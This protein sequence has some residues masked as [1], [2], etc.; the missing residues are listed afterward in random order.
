M[1]IESQF[2]P[3]VIRSVEAEPRPGKAIP[4]KSGFEHPVVAVGVDEKRRRLIMIS[5]DPDA[6]SAA[7][8][9]TD[10]QA[11]FP[12]YSVIL[13]RPIAVNLGR[14]ADAVAKALGTPTLSLA[15]LP[16]WTPPPAMSKKV[17]EKLEKKFQEKWTAILEDGFGGTFHVLEYASVNPIAAWQEVIS[18]LSHLQFVGVPAPDLAT[19]TGIPEHTSPTVQFGGLIALDPA[20]IDRRLGVCSIPLYSFSQDEARAIHESTN[21]ADVRTI[22]SNHDILQYFFPSADQVTLGLVERRGLDREAVLSTVAKSPDIGHPLGQLELVDPD[23]QLNVMIDA[24]KE[25]GLVVEGEHS[26]E[27]TEAGKNV[28][29]T[30]KWKPREGFLS[31]LSRVFSMKLDLSLK[32]FFSPGK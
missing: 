4:G 11:R 10:V 25:R 8:A 12:D 15:S 9:Q 24:L 20:E 14:M 5:G 1:T 17:K 21:L 6:R 16:N 22:L 30:V 7:M 29:T 27:M 31:K 23:T 18:Q 32:D 3:N 13:A 2:W 28:R 26:I 19:A